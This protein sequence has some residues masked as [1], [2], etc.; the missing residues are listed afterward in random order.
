VTFLTAADFHFISQED[1]KNMS[2]RQ[3]QDSEELPHF[4]EIP[5]ETFRFLCHPKRPL[6]G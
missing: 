3:Q 2:H 1:T 4:S 5:D 6:A